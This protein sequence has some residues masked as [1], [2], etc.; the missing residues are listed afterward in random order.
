MKWRYNVKEACWRTSTVSTRSPYKK[1]FNVTAFSTQNH[2]LSHN[3]NSWLRLLRSCNLL[4]REGALILHTFRISGQ[5]TTGLFS[6]LA[7]ERHLHHYH[8][9]IK[10]ESITKLSN[11]NFQR[12][13]TL[14]QNNLMN[15]AFI[16]TFFRG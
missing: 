2:T 3:A 12:T 10:T 8:T 9:K 7:N 5:P 14:Y 15:I 16:F 13:K 6:P 11:F 1:N 4:S